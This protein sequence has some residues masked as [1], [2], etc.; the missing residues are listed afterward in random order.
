MTYPR[1]IHVGHDAIGS[2][3][4]S[5]LTLGSMFSGWPHDEIRQLLLR[6]PSSTTREF[7]VVPDSVAPFEKAVYATARAYRRRRPRQG[8]PPEWDGLNS[9]VRQ[10]RTL[11]TRQRAV[12]ALVALNDLSPVRMPA[13]VT[14]RLRAF[15]PQVLHS[16]LGGMRAMRVSLAVSRCLDLPIVPHFMDDWV[17]NLYTHGQLAGA[18]RRETERVVGQVLER[19]PVLLTIG[20]DMA[21]EFTARFGRPCFVVGNS[22]DGHRYASPGDDQLSPPASVIRYVGGLHLGRDL[23]LA[24]VAEAVSRVEPGAPAWRIEIFA[25][26]ADQGR[27]QRLADTYPSVRYGGNLTPDRVPD[28]LSQRGGAPLRGVRS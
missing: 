2:V 8:P 20:N 3:S 1:V 14:A 21:E 15:R 5:G 4:N 26:D 6:E 7:L 25:P 22:V 24:Q 10:H 23:V 12:H 28:A 19:S 16:L 27:A 11:T 17:S 18:A 13:Q 9:S